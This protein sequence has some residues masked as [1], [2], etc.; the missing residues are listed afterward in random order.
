[1]YKFFPVSAEGVIVKFNQIVVAFLAVLLGSISI[2]LAATPRAPGQYV[3]TSTGCKLEFDDPTA[4]M[5]WSGSCV[6]GFAEGFGTQTART[7]AGEVMSW[8]GSMS[9]GKGEGEG[10]QIEKKNG[11]LQLTAKGIWKNNYLVSGTVTTADGLI[12]SGEFKEDQPHGQGNL[13][14]PDGSS[15]VGN[16]DDGKFSGWGV[17][18]YSQGGSFEGEWL[19]DKRHGIGIERGKDGRVIISGYWSNNVYSRP[20]DTQSS[21]SPK[22]L[23]SPRAAPIAPAL[24]GCAENGSCYGD[25]SSLTGNPKTIRVDGYYRSDGTYVRGH[26]R[27]KGNK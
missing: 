10:T 25:I 15:Y 16:F 21:S 17:F 4:K 20:L 27:S 1:M 5:E 3:A 24:G 6:D 23:P 11:K 12:Y 14:L 9:R 18:T 22:A 7:A 26:Y 2:P 8:T 13:F 19:H